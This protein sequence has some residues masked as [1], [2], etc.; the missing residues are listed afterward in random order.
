MKR[1]PYLLMLISA[2]C[3]YVGPEPFSDYV[4]PQTAAPWQDES[5]SASTPSDLLPPTG[6]L[7]LGVEEAVRAALFY[8]QSLAVETV[9]PAIRRTFERQLAAVF[10]PVVSASAAYDHERIS[11]DNINDRTERGLQLDGASSIF[12]PTGTTIGADAITQRESPAGVNDRYATRLGLSM[13]QALLRGAGEDVNLVPL[14]QARLDTLISQYELR[15]FVL[16]L[17]GQVQVVYWNYTRRNS[18]SRF[19]RS[20]W[21][22]QNSS[23]ATRRS[24]Y[25]SAACR[26]PKKRPPRRKSPAEGK[27]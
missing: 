5:E 21:S 14:R 2:S 4:G 18:R 19:S 22:L 20:R 16:A 26:R 25:A 9:T 12:L 23:F 24:G 13:S 10:D 8:N 11:G 7:N 3:S 15:G 6:P 27:V 1:L 17:V